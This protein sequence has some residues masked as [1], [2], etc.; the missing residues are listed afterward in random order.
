MLPSTPRDA[1]TPAGRPERRRISGLIGAAAA[2]GGLLEEDG[3][4][5]GGI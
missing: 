1:G 4:G 3:A 2:S 5:Q